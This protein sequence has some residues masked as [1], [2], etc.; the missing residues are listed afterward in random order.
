MKINLRTYR[1]VFITILFL[2]TLFMSGTYFY[3]ML[4]VPVLSD[5]I[6]T[7]SQTIILSILYG[8][9]F[10]VLIFVAFRVKSFYKFF[11]VLSAVIAFSVVFYERFSLTAFLVEG[12]LFIISV[13][14]VVC[15]Y[16][17]KATTKKNKK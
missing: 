10:L 4:K 15:S 16:E 2:E 7:D 12:V 11:M 1:V 6:P 13:L 8:I 9:R 5:I 17:N 3:K 14:G